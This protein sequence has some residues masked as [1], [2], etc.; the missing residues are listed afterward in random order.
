MSDFKLRPLHRQRSRRHKTVSVLSQVELAERL[1]VRPKDVKA[2]LLELGWSFH[3]DSAG[4][5]W[6][7]P[8]DTDEG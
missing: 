7:S 6:A 1:G 8:Q 4:S 2:K 3:E 5:L